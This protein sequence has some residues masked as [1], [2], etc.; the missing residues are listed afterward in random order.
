MD[1]RAAVPWAGDFELG[2]YSGSPAQHIHSV[3]ASKKQQQVCTRNSPGKHAT[4]ANTVPGNGPGRFVP[5]QTTK[6]AIVYGVANT[7]LPCIQTVPR[8]L[9]AEESRTSCGC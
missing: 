6:S 9:P 2:G 1:A 7:S 8:M 3:M 4:Y 5:L